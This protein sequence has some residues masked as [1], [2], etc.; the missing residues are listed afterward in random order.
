MIT[1]IAVY[2]VLGGVGIIARALLMSVS[3]Y[4]RTTTYTIG[5]EMFILLVN[6][7]F[8]VWAL[9]LYLNN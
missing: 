4:P 9:F 2:L 8:F 6:I 3:E 7:G 5:Q 1:F